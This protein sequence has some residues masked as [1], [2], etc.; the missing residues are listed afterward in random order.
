MQG[1]V[2]HTGADC[3]FR[4]RPQRGISGLSE[5]LEGG[6]RPLQKIVW[7]GH[8]IKTALF[9]CHGKI[10]LDTF[11]FADSYSLRGKGEKV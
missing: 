10:W 3:V 5:L 2:V 7:Q 9:R 6:Y 8:G 4:F 1:Y 11:S